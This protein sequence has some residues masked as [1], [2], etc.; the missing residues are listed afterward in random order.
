[1]L[2]RSRS[3]IRQPEAEVGVWAESEVPGSPESRQ[4]Q[5]QRQ[6][7][8]VLTQRQH[9][10]RSRVLLLHDVLAVLGRRQQQQKSRQRPSIA[11]DLGHE[12]DTSHSH[13]GGL[14]QQQQQHA[15]P[16]P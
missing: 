7:Q 16:R 6:I 9:S 14:P 13:L 2:A 10:Q 1:M 3:G 11:L 5:Q 4:Q 15:E 12:V 8:I